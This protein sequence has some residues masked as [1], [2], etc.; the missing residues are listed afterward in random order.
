V[1]QT[2]P[3]FLQKW[4]ETGASERANFQPFC[5]DLCDLIGVERPSGSKPDESENAYVFEKQVPLHQSDG[6]AT[7]GRI[8]LYKRKHF[9]MEGKQGAEEGAVKKGHGT[10]GSV[11]WD[12]A[13]VRAKKQGENYIHA[14]PAS[15]GRPPFLIIVDVGH[16]IELYSEFTRTGGIY[17][18]FP[19]A[20]SHRIFLKDLEKETVQKTLRTIWTDPGSLDP[21]SRAARVT[22]EIADKLAK[23][24]KSLEASGH[25]PSATGGFLM[26]CIFTMFAEDVN[27]LPKNSFEDL[28]KSIRNEPS[29]FVP[30]VRSV[31]DSMNDGGF[32]VALR[33][34][35]LRFNG[36]LFEERNPLPVT[37]EQIDLL[38]EAAHADWRDVEPAIF[39]T[40]LERALDPRERHKL[41]A[42]YTPRDYVERLV[43]PTVI[44]PLREQWENV[45]AEVALHQAAEKPKDAIRAVNKFL[46]QLSSTRVLDPACG[47]G[48]FLYVTMEHMKRLE[49][50]VIDLLLSLGEERL[51]FEGNTVHP[52]Q[53]LGIELNPRAAVLAELCLWIGYLQWHYR[54][55]GQVNPPEP[56]ISKFH[57]IECRDAVLAYDQAE[58]VKDEN[59][60]FVT[61][62]NGHSMKPHPVTGEQVPDESAQ[63]PVYRYE[64]PRPAEWPQADYIVGNP[65]FIG[66]ARMRD[67]LGDGYTETLRKTYK[68]LPESIDLVMFW[69]HKAALLARAGKI[70]RFGL[71]TTNSLRQTFNRRVLQTHME[72]KDPVSLR[73]AIPDHP[74][75]DSAD[76][77]AVRIAMTVADAGIN[78]GELAKV[79][80]ETEGADGSVT[81]EL[82]EQIGLIH[83][84]LKI[85]ANVASAVALNANSDMSNPGV[86]LHGS[87]F[88]VEDTDLETLGFYTRPEI[89]RYIRNYRNGKDL[90]NRPRGVRVIDLFGLSAEE[91]RE[92]YPEIYQWVGDRVKPERDQNKRESRRKNWWLFGE[93]NPKLRKQLKG[94]PR[95]IATVETSKHRFFQFLDADILPD[96]MLVNFATDQSWALGVL[97]SKTHVA[98]TLS[99]GGILGPTPRYNK[100]R[101]FE[102]FPF[103]ELDKAQKSEIG[104]IAETL[105]A[106]RKARIEAHPEL[107]MTGL[108]NVLEAVRAES[109][110][111]VKEKKIYDLGLVGVLRELHDELDAAVFAAYGWA[112]IQ[113]ALDALRNFEIYD[114]E[115]GA[116]AMLSVSIDAFPKVIEAQ[117]NEI[118]QT[119]LT[120]LVALN[121]ARATEEAKGQIRYLRPEY[122]NPD[123]LKSSEQTELEGS[124]PLQT[125]NAPLQT[126][127]KQPWPKTVAEQAAAVRK[128][129]RQTN[130]TSEQ[131]IKQV[132]QHFKGV[133]APKVQAIAEALIALGQA[134]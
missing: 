54:T 13:M 94:L 126:S 35:L 20:R 59:G 37:S 32:C 100:T 15:E 10:R 88:I 107:T 48:N 40:L 25:S 22:R 119:L 14:L 7:T 16:S 91:V 109:E 102:T 2:F 52:S 1:A 50:E 85:G 39:G 65:P 81:V 121:Q 90:T 127:A 69:W 71:I 4:A 36:G 89:G 63:I 38:I 58:P 117:K 72:A 122:Q 43:M 66:T 108:Y 115:T 57:T 11:G 19:D 78:E 84:D 31:W 116:T 27:L 5:D 67:A 64:N 21:A 99:Q 114:F 95:Y 56:V 6:T 111:T 131:D 124:H 18:P 42:H 86:K 33:H 133:R 118:E 76:A 30:L 24:A 101:C 46:D 29:Q 80:K 74:W 110:L 134:A 60:Q 45:Q 103:P 41:G 128:V 97:S 104:R 87:G 53:F 17:V 3:E 8:D 93:T 51:E 44:E 129:I 9:V 112:D 132:A 125:S 47:S 98:W 62:W 28:L 105:D 79:S 96:N 75:V 12:K 82:A 113:E 73:F 23:L 49:G 77:A 68:A 26:R 130:W 55:H 61:R 92:K 34:S 83:A 123:A 120:R 106:H 70:R